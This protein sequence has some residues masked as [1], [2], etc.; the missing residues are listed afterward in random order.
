ML[1][2]IQIYRTASRKGNWWN[3]IGKEVDILL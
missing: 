3:F 1:D 2:T